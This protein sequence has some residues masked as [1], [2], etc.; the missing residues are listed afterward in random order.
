MN[1]L[2]STIDISH[3]EHHCVSADEMAHLIV[4]SCCLTKLA[5]SYALGID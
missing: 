3:I 1:T 2:C 5:F 4:N